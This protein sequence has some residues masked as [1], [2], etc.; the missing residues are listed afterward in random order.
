MR[1]PWIDLPDRPPHVLPSEDAAVARLNFGAHPDVAVHLELL[2]EPYL[3][4]PQAPVVILNLNPGFDERDIPFHSMDPLF[5]EISRKNLLHQPQDYPFYLL[6]PR[7]SASLGHQW[8]IKKLKEPIRVA[9]LQ[10]VATRVLCVEYFPYHSR[11]YPP[12][13]ETLE[14]QRYG[15]QLVRDAIG[16]G[17]LIVI[18]RGQKRWL[19]AV[20]E[21]A[22][23]GRV[24]KLNSVQNVAISPGN[25][26]GGFSEIVSALSG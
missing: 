16:R 22:N 1:N 23:H 19:E 11:R 9:G 3:G 18:M 15:F 25:C 5:R 26:P 7:I 10:P 4:H 6:D 13:R 12:I 14:S 21:L 20:P 8:W 17:A 24:Y 2:P